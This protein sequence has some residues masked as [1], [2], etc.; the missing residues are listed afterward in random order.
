M[1][2][3]IYDQSGERIGTCCVQGMEQAQD[4]AQGLTF[5]P[6]EEDTQAQQSELLGDSE[7]FQPI[8]A[9]EHEES[10]KNLILA[11]VIGGGLCIL[12]LIGHLIGLN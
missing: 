2:Y 11:L 8:I 5:V 12:A 4:F 1:K 10:T 9:P 6:V 7:A 3:N